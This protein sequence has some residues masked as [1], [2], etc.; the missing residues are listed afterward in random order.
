MSRQNKVNPDH[1]TLAGR[2]SPDDLARERRKQ[3]GGGGLR[4]RKNRPVPP[5]MLHPDSVSASEPAARESASSV[6]SEPP[7]EMSEPKERP[8]RETRSG[9]KGAAKP[10]TAKA[11]TAKARTASRRPAKTAA[12]PPRRAAKPSGARKAASVR[13]AQPPRR[14]SASAAKTR[15]VTA[16]RR[17]S[18]KR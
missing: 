3:N 16:T 2:L 10:R 7:D 4:P 11:R 1:Y 8:R 15:K 18:R 14:R 6:A 12:R 13:K 17:S 9:K 5:W